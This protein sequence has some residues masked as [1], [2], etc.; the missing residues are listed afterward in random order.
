LEFVDRN[1]KLNPGRKSR[2]C[3]QCKAV[4]LVVAGR[5]ACSLDRH[6]V[7]RARV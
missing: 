7:A 2:S 6:V 4:E 5:S 3:R 1:Y